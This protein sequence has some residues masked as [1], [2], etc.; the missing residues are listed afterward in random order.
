MDEDEKQLL[1]DG[2][3]TYEG[4]AWNS[5]PEDEG[6]PLFRLYNP[7]AYPSGRSGAH[8]YTM[9]DEERD[10]LIDAGWSYEG[11]AWYGM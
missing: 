1:T 11:L 4:V 2:G 10:N 5:V 7:N 6:S 9:S 3:W 8:H